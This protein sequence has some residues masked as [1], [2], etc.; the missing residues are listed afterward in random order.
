MSRLVIAVYGV[1]AYAAFVGSFLYA[2]GFLEGA[3]VPKTVD[4][5]PVAPIATAVAI[6]VGLLLLF[7]IQH[8]IMARPAFKARFNRLFPEAAERSTFVLAASL[9]LG[10]ILWQWRPIHGDVW[11]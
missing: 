6:D 9:C 8:T 1:V 10:L 2:I 11:H 7:A 5:G 3:F 4:T